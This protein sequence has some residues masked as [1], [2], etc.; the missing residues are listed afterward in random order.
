MNTITNYRFCSVLAAI[1]IILMRIN[2]W[3][4]YD[5]PIFDDP[6]FDSVRER[7]KTFNL[8]DGITLVLLVWL[9]MGSNIARWIVGL[10][11]TGAVL[12]GIVT[13]VE[14]EKISEFIFGRLEPR[15]QVSFLLTAVAISLDG[16][17]AWRLLV[18]PRRFA[19]A[20][21]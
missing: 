12:I 15:E 5:G 18:W 13:I 14:F 3:V 2:T 17:V 16:F 1:G 21:K 10:L 8:D 19:K 9:A 6:I 20:G 7:T 4:I 11:L